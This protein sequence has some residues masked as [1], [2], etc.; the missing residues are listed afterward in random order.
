MPP[1]RA[2]TCWPG[3]NSPPGASSTTPVASM[4]RMRGQLIPWAIQRR[5]CSSERFN[6]KAFTA[7]STQPGVGTGTGTSRIW[8]AEG[9]PGP[10]RTTALIVLI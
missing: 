2:A 10:S 4:P 8:S 5:E 6:P 1:I 7:I 3:W 9:G